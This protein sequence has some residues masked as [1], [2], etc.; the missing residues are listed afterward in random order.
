V[1]FKTEN[2]VILGE[3]YKHLNFRVSLFLEQQINKTNEN[4]LTISTTVQFNNCFVRLYFLP[5]QPFHK[6]IVPAMLK[7][8]ITELEKSEMHNTF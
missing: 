3:D 4:G 8:I 5:V 6:R 7:G 1:F 2:E